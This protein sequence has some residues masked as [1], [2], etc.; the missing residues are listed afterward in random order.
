MNIISIDPV[1]VRVARHHMRGS[2][3]VLRDV[4]LR[5]PR[6]EYSDSGRISA[7]ALMKM[8]GPEVGALVRL[9]FR[10]S[11][12]GA[13]NTVAW[14]GLNERANIV[15]GKLLL[16]AAVSES[17]VASWAEITID[18]HGPGRR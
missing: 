7:V 11:L 4:Q 9:R 10:P 5:E 6:V 14:E 15:S 18:H 16:R 8:L 12:T 1:A 3:V 2:A 17:E 13:P